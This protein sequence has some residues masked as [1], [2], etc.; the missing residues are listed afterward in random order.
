MKTRSFVVLSLT[1]AIIIA[2]SAITF[3]SYSYNSGSPEACTGSPADKG[4]CAK[5]ECHKGTASFKAGLITSTIPVA[6]YT[7]GQVYTVT[8]KVTGAANAKKFGFQVSP[9]N[10]TGKV[11]GTMTTVNTTETKLT[12]KGKYICHKDLGTDGKGSKTWTFKW[13]APAAGTGKVTFYG[14]FLIGGKPEIMYTSKLE[15]KEAG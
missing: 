2:A 5:P 6:G 3:T 8:A 11:L 10:S 15:I 12:N 14:C 7:A 4:T 13:T 1:S 9:Q